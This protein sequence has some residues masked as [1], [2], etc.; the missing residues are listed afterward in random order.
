MLK[1]MMSNGAYPVVFLTLIVL[2]S[3]GLL[4][5][6]NS[7]TSSVVKARQEEKIKSVLESIFPEITGFDTEEEIYIT[8]G[9]EEILGYAFITEGSGYGGDISIL[10]GLDVD[11]NI[12]GV[13]ILSHTETPG[14]GGRITETGFTDQFKGLGADDV[15][16]S[17]DGGKV[18]AITGATISSRAVVEAIQGSMIEIIEK[19]N[20]R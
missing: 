16:L 20:S 3:V 5:W 1:K 2:V 19:L 8:Y 17:K 13:E 7:I 4:S 15:A 18:D 9:G 6:M 14:L 11:Y 12:K 10:V